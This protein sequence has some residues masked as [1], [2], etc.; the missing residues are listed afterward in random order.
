[1]HDEI[2]VNALKFL[3]PR[4]FSNLEVDCRNCLAIAKYLAQKKGKV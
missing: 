2:A 4:K 3:D 1:M